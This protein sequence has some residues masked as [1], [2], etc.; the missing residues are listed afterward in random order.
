MSVHTLEK[1]AQG[2]SSVLNGKVEAL[3]FGKRI[4]T[5]DDK[6]VGN[7]LAQEAWAQARMDAQT[8][9]SM[10]FRIVEMNREARDAFIAAI[11]ALTTEAREANKLDGSVDKKEA[12][13]RVATACV[14]VSKLR[15][16]A[17]AFNGAATVQGLL[18][19]V[20]TATKATQPVGI[21]HVSYVML[22]EYARTFSK[23]NAGRKAAT[24]AA[25]LGKWLEQNNP[26][27]VG[28]DAEVKA[29]AELVKAYNKLV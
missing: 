13:K 29:Y 2:A 19:Y 11:K 12:N 1:I 18:A 17:A 27:D 21:N 28:T 16:I 6:M 8:W 24:W 3:T 15:I 7:M 9:R 23:S 4:A 10:G 26:E 14:E 25:K 22:V 20:Q 5:F